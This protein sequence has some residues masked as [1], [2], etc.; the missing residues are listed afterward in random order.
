[1]GW[2]EGD[3]IVQILLFGAWGTPPPTGFAGTP[4][5]AGGRGNPD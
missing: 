1:M 4:S 2:S 3:K 5:P